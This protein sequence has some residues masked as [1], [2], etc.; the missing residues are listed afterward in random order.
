MPRGEDSANGRNHQ[1]VAK[2]LCPYC[3]EEAAP[4]YLCDRCRLMRKLYRVLSKG[5]SAGD[6]RTERS[7]EDRR[8]R[9][10]WLTDDARAALKAGT[11]RDWNY[12]EVTNP[13]DGR[14]K[15]RIRNIPVDVENELIKIFRDAG[16]PLTEAEV[17]EAWG[18]LR[19]RKGRASAA[20][21]MAQIIRSGRKQSAKAARRAKQAQPP[22]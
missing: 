6:I 4:Y 10:H 1:R 21:D 3:G 20:A 12:R 11:D 18:R 22:A 9:R 8:K 5:R 16:E 7:P 2:G 13:D 15:P 17:Y 19:L 14:L